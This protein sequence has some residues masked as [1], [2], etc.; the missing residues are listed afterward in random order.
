MNT[1]KQEQN[2]QSDIKGNYKR[3]CRTSKIQN[4]ISKLNIVNSLSIIDH[5]M[6]YCQ[7]ISPKWPGRLPRLQ[8]THLPLIDRQGHRDNGPKS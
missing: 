2:I 5:F 8:E 6:S 7:L 3:Q 1:D 4:I